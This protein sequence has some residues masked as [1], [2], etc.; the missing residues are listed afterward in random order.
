MCAC[1][2]ASRGGL[3]AGGTV[4][5]GSWGGPGGV[6]WDFNPGSDS[7]ITEVVIAHGDIVD[8]VSF[9]SFNRTTGKTVS[10]GKL[11]GS[12]GVIDK[13]S[14]NG[15]SGE[16]LT[17]IRGTTNDFLGISV[18]ESLTFHTNHN[19]YGPYGL[20]NGSVFK[21]P[22]ENGEVVGFF[23]RSVRR[24][25]HRLWQRHRCSLAPLSK[26][27]PPSSQTNLPPRSSPQFPPLLATIIQEK[28]PFFT[29]SASPTHSSARGHRVHQKRAP[30]LSL[31]RKEARQS[32]SSNRRSR[33]YR[34]WERRSALWCTSRASASSSRRLK[35]ASTSDPFS[36][37]SACKST[38]D[39]CPWTCKS[40]KFV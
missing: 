11:G 36:E 3:V 34:S 19:N 21:I 25:R 27:S 10:S 17:S 13:I 37:G 14:I 9:K 12:G 1:D 40:G 20:T 24:H 23:G 7:S 28:P 31:S 22:L 4:K 35:T 38:S 5:L 8:S 15:K 16:Y 33:R 18:V 32:P 6:T 2:E 29:A 30:P 39:I 26:T